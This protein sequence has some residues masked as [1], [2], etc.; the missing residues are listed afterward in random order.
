MLAIEIINSIL[1]LL[2]IIV[3]L[4]GDQIKGWFIKTNLIFNIPSNDPI[5]GMDIYNKK[6]WYFHLN[7]DNKGSLLAKNVRVIITKIK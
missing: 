3:A 7:V 4:F 5:S 6:L 1:M 2:T